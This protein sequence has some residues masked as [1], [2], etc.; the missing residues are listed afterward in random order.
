MKKQA[1]HCSN[2]TLF[3]KKKRLRARY[4]S[5]TLVCYTLT[6]GE[7]LLAVS[8]AFCMLQCGD[9]HSQHISHSAWTLKGLTSARLCSDYSKGMGHKLYCSAVR[10]PPALLSA[11]LMESG[12]VGPGP[13]LLIR[14]GKQS[15]HI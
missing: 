14:W 11:D 10:W 6:Q 15:L 8:L 12:E 1:W 7:N 9:Q 5:W 2:K 13:R 4:G 3:K